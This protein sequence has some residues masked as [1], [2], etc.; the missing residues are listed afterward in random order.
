M[1]CSRRELC[2]WLPVLAASTGL[3]TEK[4]SLA[5]MAARFEDLPVRTSGENRFRAILEGTT[6]E[7]WQ[8]EAHETDLAPGRMPHPGH[9]HRQEEMFL[10][11]EGTVEVTIAG[12]TT[13][14]G[15]GGVAFI[16]SNE[17]HSIRNAGATHAEYFVLALGSS[18]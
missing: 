3:A 5:S 12:R 8:L 18:E 7:G 6:H 16:A 15:P 17:E 1:T 2:L 13:R 4:A 9:R 11:R 10:I 14:L